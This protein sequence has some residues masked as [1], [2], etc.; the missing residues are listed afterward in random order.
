MVRTCISPNDDFDFF[1]LLHTP[2]SEPNELILQSIDPP[3]P[4]EMVRDF[5]DPPGTASCT[6]Y[7]KNG[8]FV[9]GRSTSAWCRCLTQ[10]AQ[11]D[12]QAAQETS[13]S[14]GTMRCSAEEPED[15]CILKPPRPGLCVMLEV[16][17]TGAGMD[18]ETL[19]RIFEPFFTTKLTGRGLGLSA[20][21]GITRSHGGGL[22]VRSTP[23]K[24]T[25]FKVLFPVVAHENE[26]A[27]AGDASGKSPRRAHGTVLLAD[28]QET[29]LAIGQHQLER[30][31]FRV[32]CARNGEE[33]LE[34]YNTMRESIDL[35]ILDLPL[36]KL[37]G[38]EVIST[39]R[40]I[41]PEIKVVLAGDHTQMELFSAFV[42]KEVSGFLRKPYT[43]DELSHVLRQLV[44]PTGPETK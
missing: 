26:T 5:L 9:F 22:W 28:H 10:T 31:G 2:P 19:S 30:L 8:H 3:L 32:V 21:L 36:P 35:I 42:G 17:D 16:S 1:S 41:N 27:A 44:I 14:T 38:K 12:N 23:N 37:N 34:I 15:G 39:L 25:T 33:C 29:V 43:L 7:G 4:E 18:Q 13:I 20:V 24:G 11:T 6:I 40:T